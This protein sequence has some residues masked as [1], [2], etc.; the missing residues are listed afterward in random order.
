MKAVMNRKG[1]RLVSKMVVVTVGLMLIA[2]AVVAPLMMPLPALV[3]PLAGTP[4]RTCI[5]TAGTRESKKEAA[6]VA[7]QKCGKRSDGKQARKIKKKVI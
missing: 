3:A 4:K 2:G 6:E 5:S 1:L 7:R